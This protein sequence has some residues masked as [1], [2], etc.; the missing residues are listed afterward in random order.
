MRCLLDTR[1]TSLQLGGLSRPPAALLALRAFGDIRD[2]GDPG[3]PRPFEGEPELVPTTPA[4]GNWIKAPAA[5]PSASSSWHLPSAAHEA[6]E[7]PSSPRLTGLW[8]ASRLAGRRAEALSAGRNVLPAAGLRGSLMVTTSWFE[9]VLLG[10]LADN[11]KPRC[12][13]PCSLRLVS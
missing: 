7:R 6:P 13:L 5:W 4:L 12:A 2:F 8:P 11:S 1:I 10:G 3:D 9:I